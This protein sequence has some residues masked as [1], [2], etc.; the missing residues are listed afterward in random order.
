[1]RALSV[2]NRAKKKVCILGIVIDNT[3]ERDD[4]ERQIIV[5]C[6]Y[7]DILIKIR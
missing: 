4:R 2:I 7:C 5:N 3:R 1:M 6:V